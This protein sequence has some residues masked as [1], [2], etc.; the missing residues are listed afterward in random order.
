MIS[1]IIIS[2]ILT[3]SKTKKQINYKFHVL[4]EIKIKVHEKYIYFF[5]KKIKN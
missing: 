2:A 5:G 3:N 4:K 1:L